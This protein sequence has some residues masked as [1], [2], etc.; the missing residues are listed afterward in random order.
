MSETPSEFD[1]LRINY[2]LRVSRAHMLAGRLNDPSVLDASPGMS[3]QIEKDLEL[4]LDEAEALAKQAATA[5]CRRAILDKRLELHKHV[6]NALRLFEVD[7][8]NAFSTGTQRTYTALLAATEAEHTALQ[9]LVEN[10][11]DPID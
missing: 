10:E 4:V 8:H 2:L 11:A 1:G 7:P 6:V 9:A 5:L 3:D